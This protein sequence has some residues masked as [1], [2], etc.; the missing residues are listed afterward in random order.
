MRRG[1]GPWHAFESLYEHE[2]KTGHEYVFAAEIA[3]GDPG[4]YERDR[5]HFH[6]E[7]GLP[8]QAVWA[9]PDRPAQGVAIYPAGLVERI[10]GGR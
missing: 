9:S 2:G 1:R 8:C 6:E 3:L 7:G 5:I 10:G 4:L